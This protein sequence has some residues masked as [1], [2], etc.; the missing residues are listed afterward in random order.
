MSG[1][2]CRKCETGNPYPP[3]TLAYQ[4]QELALAGHFLIWEM[5][6]ALRIPELVSWLARRL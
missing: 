3:G 1:H 2:L 4:R 6:A 5:I